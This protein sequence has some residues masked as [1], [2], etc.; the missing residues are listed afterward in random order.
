MEDKYFD[1]YMLSVLTQNHKYTSVT[2]IA[3]SSFRT[4]KSNENTNNP[5]TWIFLY[6][7]HTQDRSVLCVNVHMCSVMLFVIYTNDA[8]SSRFWNTWHTISKN[9]KHMH[10]RKINIKTSLRITILLRGCWREQSIQML[11]KMLCIFLAISTLA[12]HYKCS[13]SIEHFACDV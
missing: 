6:S 3:Y 12:K 4:W 11:N 5:I 13:A 2:I 10:K 8:S 1:K 7:I 9:S